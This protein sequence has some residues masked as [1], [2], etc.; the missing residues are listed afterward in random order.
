MRILPG[1]N[2][3]KTMTQ[4]SFTRKYWKI[5]IFLSLFTTLIASCTPIFQK[6]S[7]TPFPSNTPE[8]TLTP[9]PTPTERPTASPTASPLGSETNPIKL[10]FKLKPED[11][12]ALQAAED[13]AFMIT[14][15]TGYAVEVAIYADFQ[16]LSSA[17]M[18]GYVHL[19]WLEPF[20]YL[21]LSNVGAATVI[22][23]TNY[24]GT[25]AYGVQFMANALRG[26]TV[27]FDPE[28]NQSIG[29]SVNA[30][31][32]FAGTRPCFLNP[33]S[34]PGY[35]V[36]LGLLANASTPILDPIFTYSYNATIRALYIQGICDFGVSYALVGDP[37]NSSDI[38]QNIPDA[39]SLVTTIWQSDGIIPNIN[40]S[41]SPELPL[42]I[43]YQLQE[44]VIDLQDQ[45][46]GLQLIRTALMVD[47]EALR[48][49]R[50]EFY[51]PLRYAIA[52]LQLDLRSTALQIS[53][54]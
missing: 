42:N 18:N 26:F 47:V 38:I 20:E 32:Q 13:I 16:S 31:Q 21:Y 4:P 39:Q 17:V 44:A 12:A 36:P 1:Q 48:S 33:D 10:A 19:F 22:I 7:E 27:Y 24:L 35:F 49:E 37:L 46:D 53:N 9:T 30:L 2:E 50:D 52:P 51:N 25:Y 54:P 14:Q 40:L 34:V 43:R 29:D 15:E 8:L 6:P 3:S 28:T 23:S 11:T 41:S 5:W 45:P